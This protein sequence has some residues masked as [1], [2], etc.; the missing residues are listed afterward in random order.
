M[1]ERSRAR[2]AR[3]GSARCVRFARVRRKREQVGAAKVLPESC[4][5]LGDWRSAGVSALL[6]GVQKGA[7]G[8]GER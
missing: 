7:L 4:L 6:P 1:D 5:R 2:R 8:A 3:A